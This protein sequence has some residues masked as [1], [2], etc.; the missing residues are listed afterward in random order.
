MLTSDQWVAQA[1]CGRR[2]NEGFGHGIAHR[3][4]TA[5]SCPGRPIAE[6]RSIG[7]VA[8]ADKVSRRGFPRERL[9]KLMPRPGRRRIGGDVEV[10]H[11]APFMAQHDDGI[12]QSIR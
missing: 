8:I 2:R 10:D 1:L 3:S 6:D 11:L 7:C 12:E 5:I 4:A 9:H